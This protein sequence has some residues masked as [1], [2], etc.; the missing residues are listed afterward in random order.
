M[1]DMEEQD[2]RHFLLAAKTDDPLKTY[3]EIRQSVSEALTPKP[4]MSKIEHIEWLR[5]T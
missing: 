4:D 3:S 2:R 5:Q 1:A